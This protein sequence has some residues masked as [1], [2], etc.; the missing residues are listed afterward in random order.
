MSLRIVELPNGCR[1]VY[2]PP[3]ESRVTVHK[4]EFRTL[5]KSVAFQ[6]HA[7]VFAMLR[8]HIESHIMRRLLPRC[9][10]IL[11]R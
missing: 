6:S 7:F 8:C 11:I 1:A 3:E 5:S 9:D 4:K 2:V 10:A